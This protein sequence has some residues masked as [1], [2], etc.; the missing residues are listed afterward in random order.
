[1]KEQ[2][3]KNLQQFLDGRYVLVIEPSKNYKNSIKGFLANL[4]VDRIKAVSNAQEAYRELLTTKVGLFIVEWD[5]PN[6]NGLAF[7]REI[8]KQPVYKQAPFLLTS[9]E[10]LRQDVVLASEVY[11]DGYLLKPFSY[12]D[13]LTAIKKIISTK[14]KPSP[15]NQLID[16]GYQLLE[17]GKPTQAE[18]CFT[19]ALALNSNSARALCGM[20]IIAKNKG[21]K[22]EAR[23][24]F[25]N[26][27]STNS[28]YIPSYQQLLD[29]LLADNINEEAYELAK[30]VNNLSPGNP[31]YTMI[32]AKAALDLNRLEE[33][34]YYFKQTIRLS[35]KLAE[36][37]KGLGSIDLIHE[38]YES[39]MK[40]FKKSLDID[41]G[42]VSVLN[43]LGLTYVRMGRFKDGIEKYRA[44]LKLTPHEPK[45]LFN[46]GYA[47]EKIGD[48]E[49]AIFYYQRALDYAPDFEKATRRLEAL[50]AV[51]PA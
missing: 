12:E 6:E 31:K 19:N 15:I 13:F 41:R 51:R 24:L 22:E 17:Q 46:L 36:A 14:D 38:D 35:P 7:C 44:A 18:E 10:N 28:S 23:V 20:G 1:M 49:D 34:E 42:D 26:A 32:I 9:V 3:P 47:K 43:S 8:R 11:I 39:A 21:D 29:L 50:K 33:S 27:I 48:I 37:Y 5:L 2:G 25:K 30:T 40:N 4:K 16:Q 45:I